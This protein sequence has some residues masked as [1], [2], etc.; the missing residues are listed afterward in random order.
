MIACE[1]ARRCRVAKPEMQ[2]S[3]QSQSANVCDYTRADDVDVETKTLPPRV[4]CNYWCGES[5]SSVC[6]TVLYTM[7]TH[8]PASNKSTLYVL[9]NASEN[10][11][12]S[13]RLKEGR[14][15]TYSACVMY[16]CMLYVRPECICCQQRRQ[17]PQTFHTHSHAHRPRP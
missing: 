8:V 6:E 17:A 1:H 10:S 11:G 16:P 4:A 5:A 15:V 13:Q 12:V 9:T 2:A 14:V 7:C 3:K